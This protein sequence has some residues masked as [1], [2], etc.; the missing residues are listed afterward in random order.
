MET[1]E[2]RPTRGLRIHDLVGLVVGYGMAALLARSFWP[3][4]RP[5]EGVPAVAL[6][7]D[8]LWLGLAMSGPI[9]LL[10]DRRGSSLEKSKD[11]PRRR[12]RPGRLI[13]APEPV[14]E[15][16]GRGPARFKNQEPARYT[17]AELAWMVI[18]G[19]WIALTMFVVPALSVDTP[20]ALVGLLQIVAALGLWLVVPRRPTPAEIA[21]AWTHT[22]ASTL[23][24]TWPVAWICL[25]VLSRSL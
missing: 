3:S 24:W 11:K 19:Y 15:P 13:S 20:W 23:L 4:S 9:L 14:N 1:L 22:A 6:V 5:I 17:K 18:G 8:F 10:L 2:K 25:I 16:V 12:P 21:N 7:L